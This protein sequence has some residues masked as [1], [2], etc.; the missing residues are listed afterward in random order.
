[1]VT[2]EGLVC[3]G[4]IYR[5][6]EKS[7]LDFLNHAKPSCGKYGALMVEEDEV[8][9][10]VLEQWRHVTTELTEKYVTAS[11]PSPARA[12]APLENKPAAATA[13]PTD[14]AKAVKGKRALDPAAVA[15]AADMKSAKKMLL[16]KALNGNGASSAAAV[17]KSSRDGAAE[18]KRRL[19]KQKDKK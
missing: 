15:A 9:S 4:L 12:P 7:T 2:V 18:K 5:T 1:V 11:V 17:A 14:D 8:L 6:M 3:E 16:E 13:S 19:E 10:Q